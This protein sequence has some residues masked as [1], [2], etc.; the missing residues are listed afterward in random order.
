MAREFLYLVNETSFKTTATPTVGTNAFYIRLDGGNAFTMRPRRVDVKVP[1][2]GG[3]ATRRFTVADKLE[4]KG[5]LVTKLY[6]S[7]LTEFLLGKCADASG[8]DIG[9]F[10]AYHAIQRSDNTYKRRGYLGCKVESWTLEIS[11][12]STIG[13][14]TLELAA[15]QPVGV[16][17]GGVTSSDPDATAFPAP[18][19][20]QLPS[21]PYVYINAS[22][23]LTVGSSR[24]KFSGVTIRSQN[25]LARRYFATPFLDVLKFVGRET[26]MEVNHFF[27]ASPD[28]RSVY[29]A[30]TEQTVSF[31]LDNGDYSMQV[32]LNDNN[33]FDGVEDNL[34][35]DDVYTQQ[36]TI[37]NQWEDGTG[38]LA[39][40]FTEPE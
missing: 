31:T 21:N 1:Y 13:T 17:F 19:D 11:E 2:G 39:L 24:S 7:K 36:L 29:E 18:T 40:A 23:G 28:D 34:A 22:G 30:L 14:L 26:T 8:G 33:V 15:S 6:A 20:V 9:S 38:D 27:M 32:N 37:G 3:L 5:R 25:K 12:D 35:L 4:L 16:S 10:T